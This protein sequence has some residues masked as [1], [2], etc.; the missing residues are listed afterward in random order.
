MRIIPKRVRWLGVGAGLAWLFDP[1][2]GH[3][4][5]ARI[6]DKLQGLRH[7]LG[8]KDETDDRDLTTPTAL[9]QPIR[10]TG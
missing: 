3:H 1:E 5:R 10:A 6:A 7:T 9:D 4:R 2:L 8:P